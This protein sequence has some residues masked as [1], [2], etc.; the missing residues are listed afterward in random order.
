V[1]HDVENSAR[2]QVRQIN[3]HV[4]GEQPGLSRIRGEGTAREPLMNADER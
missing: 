3:L 1:I 2:Q 4:R